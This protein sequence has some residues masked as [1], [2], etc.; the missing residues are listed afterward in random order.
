MPWETQKNSKVELL[1][2]KNI[3]PFGA[4]Q[5]SSPNMTGEEL[6][7][8]SD[9]DPVLSLF[10]RELLVGLTRKAYWRRCHLNRA[11]KDFNSNR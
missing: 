1:P 4:I 9:A 11:L 5:T 2:L 3:R 10:R 8:P 7:R 6:D